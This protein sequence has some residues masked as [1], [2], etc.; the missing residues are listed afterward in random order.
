MNITPLEIRQ[1]EF[2]K[3]FRGYDKDEVKAFFL[4]LFIAS[5]KDDRS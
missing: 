2:E 4:F 1:K 5:I 3:G